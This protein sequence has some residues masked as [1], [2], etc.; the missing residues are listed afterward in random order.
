[1]RTIE[2]NK[3]AEFVIVNGPSIMH[4]EHALFDDYHVYDHVRKVRFEVRV[5]STKAENDHILKISQQIDTDTET[6]L[7]GKVA[8]VMKKNHHCND[9]ETAIIWLSVVVQNAN[10]EKK[11]VVEYSM[12]NRTGCGRFIDKFPSF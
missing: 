6:F 8:G 10:H 2:V 12:K 5:L 9:L 3:G 1:M 11:C 7:F 4:F